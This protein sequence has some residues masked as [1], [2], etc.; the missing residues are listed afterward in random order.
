MMDA[1][2]QMNETPDVITIDP[3][4]AK[5]NPDAEVIQLTT[6]DQS[7]AVGR[8]GDA[9]SVMMQAGVPPSRLIKSSYLTVV[10]TLVNCTFLTSCADVRAFVTEVILPSL[11]KLAATEAQRN[12]DVK[13]AL[14]EGDLRDAEPAGNA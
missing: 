10:G 11:D 2:D 7:A 4:G 8:I 12:A 1:Q 5:D 13:K 6:E 9:I 14:E 3:T